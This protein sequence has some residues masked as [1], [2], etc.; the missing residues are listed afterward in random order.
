MRAALLAAAKARQTDPGDRGGGE[1]PQERARYQIYSLNQTKVH[2]CLYCT[3]VSPAHS[4]PALPLP[5][6]YYLSDFFLFSLTL[7]TLALADAALTSAS[8]DPAY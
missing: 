1:E 2:R 3:A 8:P 6:F 5:F 7:L 4:S